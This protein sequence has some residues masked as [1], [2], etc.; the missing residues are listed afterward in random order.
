MLNSPLPLS[1]IPHPLFIY[2]PILYIRFSSG[3][4]VFNFTLHQKFYVEESPFL[5]L[6]NDIVCMERGAPS[7]LCVCG[8]RESERDRLDFTQNFD[9]FQVTLTYF[10]KL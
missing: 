1:I 4:H 6:K 7:T 5:S 10:M 9:Y 2:M 8:S 3:N